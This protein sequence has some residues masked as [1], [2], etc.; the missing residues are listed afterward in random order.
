MMHSFERTF[1]FALAIAFLTTVAVAVALFDF[2]A[3]ILGGYLGLSLFAFAI[4]ALDKNAAQQDT[5]RTSESF[6]HTLA[7]AGGWPG[8]LIAQQVL[9]HKTRKQ[10]FRIVF[11]GTVVLNL[12]ALTWLSTPIG[13]VYFQSLIGGFA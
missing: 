13:S 4:Y 9:R 2:P 7:L 3:P 6:L 10:P 8:A 1:S 5:W 12:C 11:W